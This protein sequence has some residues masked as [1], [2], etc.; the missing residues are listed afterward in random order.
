MKT[1]AVI[2][3]ERTKSGHCSRRCLGLFSDRFDRPEDRADCYLQFGIREEL[4]LGAGGFIPT[5]FCQASVLK[6]QEL[7][8]ANAPQEEE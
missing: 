1:N 6:A 2:T 7:A 8:A 4:K 5:K 3:V